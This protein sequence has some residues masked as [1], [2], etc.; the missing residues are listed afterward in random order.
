M[1]REKETDLTD[2]MEGVR[3]KENWRQEMKHMKSEGQ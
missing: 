1:E 2:I 3:I